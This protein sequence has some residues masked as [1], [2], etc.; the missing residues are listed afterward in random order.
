MPERVALRF[1]YQTV[2]AVDYLHRLGILHRDIKPENLLL[3]RDFN[4][5]L[6]DFGWSC[7][8]NPR[9]PRTS[10]CGTYEYMSPEIVLDQRHDSKVD[11]W[12]LGV[13]LYELLHGEVTR[14]ST[15]LWIKLI[16]ALRRIF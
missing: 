7:R 10:I 5:K 15:F 3:D 8:W 13:L 16:R 14:L 9:E 2:L 6:C 4:I 11:T 1:F 12:C